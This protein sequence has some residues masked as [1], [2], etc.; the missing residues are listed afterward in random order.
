MSSSKNQWQFPGFALL[1][2]GDCA[3]CFTLLSKKYTP[4]NLL[5]LVPFNCLL[6]RNVDNAYDIRLYVFSVLAY[7]K[8]CI[9]HTYDILVKI[10][11]LYLYMT[12]VK[13]SL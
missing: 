4:T 9:F 5:Q 11:I 6:C 1:L 8:I 12:W 7:V 2:Q 13:M 3:Y 10:R